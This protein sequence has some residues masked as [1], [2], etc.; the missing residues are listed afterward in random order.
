MCSG[1]V[2]ELDSVTAVGWYRIAGMDLLV[3]MMEC[4]VVIIMED[5]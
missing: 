4:A 1:D 2:L 3:L 5:N